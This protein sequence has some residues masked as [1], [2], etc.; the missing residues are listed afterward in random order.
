MLRFSCSPGEPWSC[1]QGLSR[2][3]PSSLAASCLLNSPVLSRQEVDF[4]RRQ[5]QDKFLF[6]IL[7]LSSSRG[8]NLLLFVVSSIIHPFCL[9]SVD[10]EP[11]ISSERSFSFRIFDVRFVICIFEKYFCSDKARHCSC[12]ADVCVNLSGEWQ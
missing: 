4:Q 9:C 5:K 10:A 2:L 11:G 1:E 7:S 8:D 6:E 3:Q 12:W